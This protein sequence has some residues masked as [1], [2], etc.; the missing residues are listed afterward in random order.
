MTPPNGPP[1]PLPNWAHDTPR[2]TPPPPPRR[3]DRPR[4]IC[5]VGQAVAIHEALYSLG[6]AVRQLKEAGL[7][8]DEIRQAFWAKMLSSW[9][10]ANE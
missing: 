8:D 4:V 6:H 5:D 7:S 3:T 2:P 1:P 9:D 10:E